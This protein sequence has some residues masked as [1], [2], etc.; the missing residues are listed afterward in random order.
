MQIPV[1]RRRFLSTSAAVGTAFGFFTST[2]MA[3]E[4]VSASD[5]LTVAVLGVNGQGRNHVKH[6]A[7]QPGVEVA[8]I[9]DVDERVI[10]RAIAIAEEHQKRKPVGVRDFR[11]LLDDKSIDIVSIAMPNHWHAPAT[12]MACAAGKHVYVEKPCSQT[13]EEG[14]LAVQAA[15]KYGRVVQMGNQRR[16]RAH[17]IEAIGKIQAGEIGDVLLSRTWYNSRRG[18]IGVGKPAEVP[19]E[20]DYALW[21]GPA[22]ERPYKDNL[23]HYNWHW[24]W[25]WGNGELGNNGIHAI[26]VARWGMDV[27][28]PTRVTSTGSRVRFDDDQETPDT[29]F[30]AFHFG[31]R[32]ITWEGLSWSPYGPGG[33]RFGTSFHGDKGSMHLHDSGYT[34]FDLQNKALET[35]T[36]SGGDPEHYASFLAAIRS[37]GRPSSDI[38]DAH[39]S[40]LLCHLGN[41]AHRVGRPVETNPENG[42]LVNDTEAQ[43]LWGRE[44]RQGWEP[45]GIA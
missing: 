32:M 17:Y 27:D 28:Y 19:K 37:G 43:Q 45:E 5:T 14:E 20:L 42:H 24:H 33:S 21:Q 8:Y 16:S 18:S 31:E 30:V 13:A 10:P 22:P 4:R 34:I 7:Q 44:Y 26:D 2:S 41:I 39:Q 15:R 29:H 6:F 9:C 1:D 25:H 23:L 12:I 40:T 11:T 3:E 38:E 35:V 36:R